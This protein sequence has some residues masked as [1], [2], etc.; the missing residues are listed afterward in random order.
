MNPLS[1]DPIKWLN[2]GSYHTMSAML[3]A[4]PHIWEYIRH[5]RESSVNEYQADYPPPSSNM[6]FD[7]FLETHKGVNYV[8]TIIYHRDNDKLVEKFADCHPMGYAIFRIADRHYSA[9]LDRVMYDLILKDI[10]VI[11]SHRRRYMALKMIVNTCTKLGYCTVKTQ[12]SCK[13][14]CFSAAADV[15]HAT[16]GKILECVHGEDRGELSPRCNYDGAIVPIN[17]LSALEFKEFRE[18]VDFEDSVAEIETSLDPLVLNPL[19]EKIFKLR[20][21]LVEFENSLLEDSS[22]KSNIFFNVPTSILDWYKNI[23]RNRDNIRY[24]VAL[25]KDNNVYGYLKYRTDMVKSIPPTISVHIQELFVPECNRGHYIASKM[26][27]V[28]KTNVR[29]RF[30]YG[31]KLIYSVTALKA[32][33]SA[34][35]L[36]NRRGFDPF[37]IQFQ[38]V[39]E[40]K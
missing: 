21:Q 35:E 37:A 26:I 36:Y 23:D 19:F 1:F 39:E 34:K 32:N 22:H 10:Y 38:S 25:D 17:A 2:T 8:I 24:I 6:E 40:N 18:G 7:Q 27:D 31:S 9:A 16:F 5:L 12:V 30:E 13:D 3:D 20:S 11:P 15:A 4:A 33:E 14:K 29:E 28:L